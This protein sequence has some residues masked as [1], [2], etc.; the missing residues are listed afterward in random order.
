M[1]SHTTT[2]SRLP[3]LRLRAATDARAFID[4]DGSERLLAL[5]SSLWIEAD[6]FG[7]SL[8]EPDD[9]MDMLRS[10]SRVIVRRE[11]QPITFRI[12][13]G[14]GRRRWLSGWA[15]AC[16]HHDDEL[17]VVLFDATEQV[18]RERSLVA[19]LQADEVLSGREP[20]KA[21]IPE[22]LRIV[23]EHGDWDYGEFWHAEQDGRMRL[24][25]AH[26]CRPDLQGF[27][28]QSRKMTR[29]RGEGLPGR[30]WSD[31]GPVW[32]DDLRRSSR[33][34]DRAT[35]AEEYGLRS[36]LAVPVRAPDSFLGSLLLCSTEVRPLD[37]HQLALA[38][39]VARQLEITLARDGARF[40]SPIDVNAILEGALDPIAAFDM[41]GV[42]IEWNAAAE[43]VFG[44]TKEQIIGRDA[45][46]LML[47]AD[48]ASVDDTVFQG[49]LREMLEK[50]GAE[51]YESSF[52]TREGELLPCEISIAVN[53]GTESPLFVATIRDLTDLRLTEE[54]FL[55]AQKLEQLGRLVGGVAHD[56][57]NSLLVINGWADD[58]ISRLTQVGDPSLARDATEIKQAARRAAELAQ[59]LV[60]FSR[61]QK[62]DLQIRD[63]NQIVRETQAMLNTTVGDR[64]T[65]ELS[66][67]D[68]LG[69]VSVDAAQIQQV[70]LNLATNARDA[71][72]AGGRLL[73]ETQNIEIAGEL[74]PAVD[75]H[76]GT[77][78][79][80]SVAD[81]GEG[82]DEQTRR[83]CFEPFFT[84]KDPGA[85][86]GLGL[87]SVYGTVKQSGGC[88][89]VYSEPGHGTTFR[90]Y[91]PHLSPSGSRVEN[92]AGH[93]DAAEP[94]G[95]ET[96]LLVEDDELALTL[97]HMML[98]QLGYTVL[99]A[100]SG[101]EALRVIDTTSRPVDLLIS[102][103]VMPGIDGVDLAE[104]L[105]ARYP[106]ARA[107]FTSGYTTDA[108][109]EH[110]VPSPDVFLQ[111]PFD[112]GMLA[113]RV[114]S[115][116]DEKPSETR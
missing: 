52:L 44:W 5:P 14:H 95:H 28:D 4:V 91:F 13:D 69:H 42:V 105:L 76:P 107:L 9:R 93:L 38:V 96:I 24:L 101:G 34:T 72:P 84:T 80:L 94:R 8:V 77:Y 79:S 46:S 2:H 15:A 51:R 12:R 115:V 104:R 109:L 60:A 27:L 74:V 102:D 49:W 63:L 10:Y 50:Q 53:W 97:V 71:M 7:A 92:A 32:V 88:I 65:V 54:K 61:R 100:S 57:N 11:S 64:I 20:V 103:V 26:T 83:R 17:E 108:A 55:Q 113:R 85:G 73:I 3:V 99:S 29:S 59:Q 25:S 30:A 90:I 31:G 114:R 98:E 82:M 89:T 47:P 45:R 18:M 19:Q 70:L 37:P 67:A 40:A 23:C 16:E 116:L 36:A 41:N 1:A 62:L 68:G 75:L 39:N 110:G 86:S 87:S 112:I 111:K 78:V 56:F 106:N 6:N 58:L 66:L 21:L 48:R 33:L 22:I 35:I 43:R 81:T